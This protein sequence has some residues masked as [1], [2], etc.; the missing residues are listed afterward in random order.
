MVSTT[1][2]NDF[3]VSRKENNIFVS[4]GLRT[5]TE[6]KPVLT[7]LCPEP[8]Q[9]CKEHNPCSEGQEVL[10]VFCPNSKISFYNTIVASYVR[11]PKYF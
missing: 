4:W 10:S 1:L 8:A 6:S 11:H 7:A 9:H 3:T 2:N 5:H